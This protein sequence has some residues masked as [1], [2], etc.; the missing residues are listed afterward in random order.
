MHSEFPGLQPEEIT[1]GAHTIRLQSVRR[2]EGANEWSARVLIVPPVAESDSM[3]GLGDN[4]YAAIADAF[5]RARK[6]VHA[7]SPCADAEGA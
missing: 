7:N 3:L 6:H 1:E 2:V 4:M 5:N